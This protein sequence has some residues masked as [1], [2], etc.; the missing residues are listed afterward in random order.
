MALLRFG[1]GIGGGTT[2]SKDGGFVV[3]GKVLRA[4]AKSPNSS[5]FSDVGSGVF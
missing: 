3:A 5:S 1:A 2:L 4:C